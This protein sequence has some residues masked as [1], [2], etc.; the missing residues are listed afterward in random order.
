MAV[1][2]PSK[3]EII[4]RIYNRILAESTAIQADLDG[5]IIGMI[6]KLVGAELDSVW[7][8]IEELYNQ[9][10]LTT[11]TGG[12]LD[13]MG[14]LIGVQRKTESRATTLGQTKA[15]RF[16]NLGGT[17]I[18]IPT[19]TRVWKA[20]EINTAFFTVEGAAV[21]A[22]Q[23][24]DVHVSAAESGPAFNVGVGE[25][26]SH[27][28]PTT[29]I[30]VTNIIPIENGSFT[31]SDASYRERI[32]QEYRR[33]NVLNPD[34]TIALLRSI[35]GV[36]D[37]LLLNLSR[38]TGTFDAIVVPYHQ[39]Q[40]N[41][42]VAQCQRL[43]DDAVPVGVSGKAK[44]PIARILDIKISLKFAVTFTNQDS[45]RQAVKSQ[46]MSRLDALP[47]ENGSGAGSV[48][49]SQ[50]RN[51]AASSDIGVI[52]ASITGSLDGFPLSPEGEIRVA[53]GEQIVLR[54]LSVQ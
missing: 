35:D 44:L 50:L 8:Y 54:T 16:T 46:I 28:V 20:N 7:A 45:V 17:T 27:N 26:N 5:S 19:S 3:N 18:N 11:A 12:S 36:R 52:D 22:G 41:D 33:R 32:L 42:V 47:I 29:S 38:G 49:M 1:P 4:D 13:Q 40:A 30:K 6:V 2:R 43:L 51:I 34:N 48:F 21:P 37:V 9:S 14:L 23:S 39:T 25:L 15:V 24:V 53:L 31:E 10:N